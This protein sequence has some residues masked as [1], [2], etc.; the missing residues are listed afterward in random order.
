VTETCE[1]E[2]NLIVDVQVE[3]ATAADNAYLK[4]AVAN[5]EAVL[6]RQAQE[7]SADG[8]YYS[9]ENETYAKEQEKEIHYT[10][11]PG[12]PGRFDYEQTDEGVL[13]IDRQSGERQLAEEYKPGRYRFRVDG[14]WR[15]ITDQDIATAEC[16][17]RTQELPRELFNRRGNVEATIFQLCYLTNKKKLKYRGKFRIQLWALCRAAWINMRRIASYQAKQAAV[18]A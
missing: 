5:S 6:D 2:L 16:R 3:P 8:A 14:K 17:R 4:E 11:F 13:I 12:K 7:I 10:G 1:G 18:I 15:Y 9:E